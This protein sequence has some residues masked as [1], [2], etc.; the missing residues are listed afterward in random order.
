MLPPRSYS[1][2]PEPGVAGAQRR[3]AGCSGCQDLSE[4]HRPQCGGLGCVPAT[5]ISRAALRVPDCVDP[6]KV[7]ELKSQGLTLTP[8]PGESS[9]QTS[10]TFHCLICNQTSYP[11]GSQPW[12]PRIILV[13]SQHPEATA[14]DFGLVGLGP[15]TSPFRSGLV[16]PLCSRG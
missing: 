9:E 12:Q 7:K 16:A 14:R 5:P 8:G 6:G 15:G 1:G 13:K 4:S 3:N 2:V 10:P 11:S